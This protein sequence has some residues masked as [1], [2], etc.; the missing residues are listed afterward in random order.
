MFRRAHRFVPLFVAAFAAAPLLAQDAPPPE[1]T[2]PKWGDTAELG[3]VATSGNSEGS[4][5]GLKNTLTRENERSLFELKLGGVRVE[6]TTI[7]LFAVG[8]A[9]DFTR[10]EE[11]STATTAE[12]YFLNGRYD[13]KITDSFFWFAGAGWDRNRPAGVD[14]RYVA[15][16]G[17]GNIW[18]DTDRHK[19]RTDYSATGTNQENVVDDPEFDETFVGVRLSSTF[20][21]KFGANDIGIFTNDTTVDENLN[22]TD[23]W[24]VNMTN[25]VSINMS[26]HLALKVSLQWLYD[27]APSLKEVDL[28]DPGDLTTPIGRV[29]V[30]LD[31]LDSLFT[32]AL[33]VTY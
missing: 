14:N 30:E 4:T 28:F 2:F 9:T 24:R 32:T 7:T 11:K 33:V 20:M 21:Q 10:V 8:N 13:H 5:I 1:K 17:V 12:N 3:W 16:A 25:A 15:S 27:N 31:E 18:F 29:L 23:D 19:W 26:T 6:T 22:Q